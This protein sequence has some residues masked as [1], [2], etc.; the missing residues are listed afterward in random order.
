[1]T[2][3]YSG[4]GVA[5]CPVHRPLPTCR[6]MSGH[7]DDIGDY[8]DDNHIENDDV[9]DIMMLTNSCYRANILLPSSEFYN[10]SVL[11][12]TLETLEKDA[13]G[14][15]NCLFVRPEMARKSYNAG[16][17]CCASF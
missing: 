16:L 8:D 17:F 5:L 4:E 12:H 15:E 3:S 9:G 1:M 13:S 6:H 10:N 7:H 2:V 14:M 11:K